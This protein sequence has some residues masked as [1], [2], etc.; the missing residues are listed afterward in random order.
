M[1][2]SELVAVSGAVGA[3]SSRTAKTE[4]IADLLRGAAP[5][6]VAAA[7]AFLSG[8]LTQ[9]RIGV[10]Y[11][12]LREP[13]APAQEP[14]LT[15]HEVD[16]A[17]GAIGALQGTGSQAA[18]RQALDHVLERADPT[19]QSFLIRLLMG[20]VGHGALEG[21]MAAAI[22]KAAGVPQTDVRRALTLNGDLAAIAKTALAEGSEGLNAVRL[23]VGRPLSPML[24]STAP[25]VAAALAKTGPATVEWKLD[26]A[27]VQIHKD[28]DRITVFTRT[29][30]DVT[31]RLPEVIEAARALPAE[32]AV[33]DG[34]VIALRQ[35]GRP[36]PFQVTGSRF[37]SRRDLERLQR[38]IPLDVFLFDLLHVDGE[39]LLDAP[40][41]E[42]SERLDALAPQLRVPHGTGQEAFDEAVTAG[43]EGVMVKALDAPYAAGRRGAAWLK[44]KP[45][46]TL[47]LVVLAAEWGHGRRRGYLSNLHLG[48]RDGDGWAMLGKTFKGLTDELLAWQ[49]QRF[50]EIETHRTGHAVHVKPEQV[51]EIAFD[52]VQRSRRYPSGMALRF[53]RVK[54]YRDDKPA[55]EADTVETVRALG[56]LA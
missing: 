2:L 27:R 43:H 55:A 56:G 34:E 30:E 40:L 18:R 8:R 42:R 49:T 17:F 53:A 9:R 39:D 13:P 50:L 11:A 6:E 38:E 36:H 51:V 26:G 41:A 24:A 3:T 15:V 14:T 22:A 52:G 25:D 5:D 23:E 4:A 19:E 10:G 44:V 35:D 31:E 21:V 32:R 48:A 45:V 33:L 28:G 12:Q 37:G 29:L 7:V 46:H 1:Q 54:R 20:D 47:D 16:E